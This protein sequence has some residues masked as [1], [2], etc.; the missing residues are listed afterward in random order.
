M[1]KEEGGMGYG[2]VK[3]GGKEKGGVVECGMRE[4]R[5]GRCGNSDSA[6]PSIESPLITVG[7]YSDTY[8]ICMQEE[9]CSSKP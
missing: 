1:K 9:M 7:L 4:K 2:E 5:G 6:P 3:R 8:T